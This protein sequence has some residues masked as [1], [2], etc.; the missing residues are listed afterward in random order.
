MFVQDVAEEAIGVWEALGARTFPD[1]HHTVL[2]RVED[3]SLGKKNTL[4][5][6]HHNRAKLR[7]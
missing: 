4:I 6:G 5:N 7:I 3:A 2:L 1:T